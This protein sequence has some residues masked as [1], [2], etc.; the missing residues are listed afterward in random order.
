MIF[1]LHKTMNK[2]SFK[3][4]LLILILA[5]PALLYI[6]LA[7]T[8]KNEYKIQVFNPKSDM[9]PPPANGDTMHRIPPFSFVSQDGKTVT[10][11]DFKGKIY[12][13]DFIFTRC[14]SICPVMTSEL[15]RVQ[16]AFK[17]N[18]DIKILSHSIDPLYDS[19]QV[20][21][22][23]GDKH[24]ADYNFW[25]FV[26]GDSTK[27]YDMARC[28]YFMAIQKSPDSRLVFDHSDKLILIDKEQRIRGFYS[29]TKREEVDRL[30]IEMQILLAEY[31]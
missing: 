20:L 1:K 4:A 22:A 13:A 29:G 28:G 11:Q 27:I 24:K 12:V 15:T 2:N 19:T 21:K 31:Q 10:E 3:V 26:T 5:V 25:T 17:G 18:P 14:P 8:G 9:C 23:Y 7:G 30:I 16:E 6:I